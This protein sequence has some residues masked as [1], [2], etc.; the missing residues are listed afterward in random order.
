MNETATPKISIAQV[1]LLKN[2]FCQSYNSLSSEADELKH[3]EL[4]NVIRDSTSKI[5]KKDDEIRRKDLEL[6][7]LKR[8]MSHI[9]LEKSLK[10]NDNFGIQSKH[11]SM[12]T[13]VYHSSA[14]QSNSNASNLAGF[15]PTVNPAPTSNLNTLKSKSTSKRRT[16]TNSISR[17]LQTQHQAHETSNCEMIQSPELEILSDQELAKLKYSAFKNLKQNKNLKDLILDLISTYKNCFLRILRVSN[18]L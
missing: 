4:M 18:L 10:K 17:S 2:S 12:F 13:G 11:K 15:V 14:L 7:D 16:K 9:N 1:N 8:R 3:H 6:D 5:K